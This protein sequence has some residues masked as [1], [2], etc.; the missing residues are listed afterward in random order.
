[1]EKEH[2]VLVDLQNH[3]EKGETFD[4]T[5]DFQNIIENLKKH[6]NYYDKI[7]LVLDTLNAEYFDNNHYIEEF[8]QKEEI[9]VHVD[10]YYEGDLNSF[11]DKYHIEIQNNI[12]TELLIIIDRLVLNKKVI[13]TNSITKQFGELRELLDDNPSLFFYLV[14]LKKNLGINSISEDIM[15]YNNKFSSIMI[16]LKKN[17]N[18]LFDDV[19]ELLDRIDNW[20]VEDIGWEYDDIGALKRNGKYTFGGGGATECLLEEI[21]RLNISG[22]NSNNNINVNYDFVYGDKNQLKD[23]LNELKNQKNNLNE[24]KK[25]KNILKIKN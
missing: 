10:K 15:K 6:F 23:F 7:T 14:E 4:N 16:F 21:T 8:E 18:L 3:F 22:Y 13:L 17:F 9:L 20:N 11:F 2:L 25:T 24:L 19:E 1:M 5:S 12:H